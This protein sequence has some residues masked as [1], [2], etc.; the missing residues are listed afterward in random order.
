MSQEMQALPVSRN[1]SIFWAGAANDSDRINS[2]LIISRQ[3]KLGRCLETT[4][5]D[6]F[7]AFKGGVVLSLHPLYFLGH[8]MYAGPCV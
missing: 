2:Y 4:R 1:S 5:S 3:K 8:S 6:L 7:F